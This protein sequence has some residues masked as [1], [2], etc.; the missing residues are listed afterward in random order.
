MDALAAGFWG[1]FFGTAV[2]MLALSL[3]AFVRSHRQVALMAGLSAVVSAAFVIAYLGFLPLQPATEGRLLAH[4]AMLAAVPL[5]L[6]LLAML[7]LLR[8]RATAQRIGAACH[9]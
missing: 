5:A 3:V 1:A 7:G 8:Q 2:L 9:L 4:V 6:M